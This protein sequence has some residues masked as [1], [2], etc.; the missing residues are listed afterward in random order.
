M[1]SCSLVSSARTLC[2]LSETMAWV[3]TVKI[4][5]FL[6]N[7]DHVTSDDPFE[8]VRFPSS[9]FYAKTT[10]RA[11]LLRRIIFSFFFQICTGHSVYSARGYE[12]FRFDSADV[13]GRIAV[14]AVRLQVRLW[15]GKQWASRQRRPRAQRAGKRCERSSQRAIRWRAD[16]D[17]WRMTNKLIAFVD[18]SMSSCNNCSL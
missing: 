15:R 10:F 12:T 13:F 4:V 7:D 3:C 9:S 1:S 14:F 8:W 5:F 16:P 2:R 17:I 6:L 18:E 11:R